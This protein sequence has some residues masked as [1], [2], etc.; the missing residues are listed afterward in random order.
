MMKNVLVVI[1][2]LLLL[3]VGYLYY[4]DFSGKKNMHLESKVYTNDLKDSACHRAH[5]A[6]V[7]LDSLNENIT[8]IKGKRKELETEQKK[9]ESDWEAGYRGLEAKKNNFLKKG[10]SITQEEAQQFQGQLLQEQQQIDAR[11]QTLNQKMSEKSFSFM[12]DI[13]KKLKEFLATYNKEKKYMYILTTGTGLDYLVYKDT[14]L[15]ITRDVIKGMNEKLNGTG[16]K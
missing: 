5:I 16:N 14:S 4:Y 11:K 15:N 3:A 1:N 10:A 7:E 13:Q 9:I 2:L 12:D 6:Y 8:Y